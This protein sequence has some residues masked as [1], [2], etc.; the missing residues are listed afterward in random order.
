MSPTKM[1][2]LVPK[3]SLVW[4]RCPHPPEAPDLFRIRIWGPY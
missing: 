1:F 4:C 2:V 3:L